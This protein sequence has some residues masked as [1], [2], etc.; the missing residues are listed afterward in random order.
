M[1]ADQVSRKRIAPCLGAW[2]WRMI[3]PVKILSA[4]EVSPL[5]C[6]ADPSMFDRVI[7]KA[8]VASAAFP[9]GWPCQPGLQPDN[10]LTLIALV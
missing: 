10:R 1:R 7:F 8:L 4:K 9:R 2:G 6:Y 5:K 3:T